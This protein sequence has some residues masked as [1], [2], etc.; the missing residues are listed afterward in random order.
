[1][2]ISYQI[3]FK[4][5]KMLKMWGYDLYFYSCIYLNNE[6]NHNHTMKSI[7]DKKSINTKYFNV[8]FFIDYSSNL[9]NIHD[10]TFYLCGKYTYTIKDILFQ[11]HACS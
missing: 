3:F 7:L 5:S 4:Y 2:I 6:H 1:M 8:V 9:T 10:N 11:F